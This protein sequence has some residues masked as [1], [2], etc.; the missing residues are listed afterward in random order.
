MNK[1]SFYRGFGVGVLFSAV[2]LGTSCLI[3]T[4]DARVIS[5]AKKLGMVFA[6]GNTTAVDKNKKENNASSS[7]PTE[8]SDSNK[9][10]NKT[11]NV[12]VTTENPKV[13]PTPEPD[14]TT[15]KTSQKKD[16]KETNSM[17]EEKDKMEKDI[18]NEA[19]Q[20]EIKA[21]DWSSTVS[22]RLEKMGII[23]DATDFDLYLS[24]N[25]Y[26]ESITAGTYSVSAD[27]S[28]QDIAK[29]ITGK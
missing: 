4:S 6:D 16:K 27:D 5:Q 8:K 1:K 28:Y 25:G 9:K 20:L 7:A 23:K 18:K 17:D 11:T 15:I 2:I 24:Q 22:A 13:V 21:G 10:N 19:K 29:K 26:G 3:R 12:P 14:D